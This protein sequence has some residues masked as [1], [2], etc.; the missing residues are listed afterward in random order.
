LDLD[1][2]TVR[3]LDDLCAQAE[4]FCGEE[5]IVFPGRVRHSRNPAVKS[6]ALVRNGLRDLLALMPGGW[7]AF[8]A[9]ER[10]YRS[11]ANNAVIGSAPRSRFVTRWL[12]RIP[13]LPP[14]VQR[15]YCGIGP[16]LVQ[17]LTPQ[18]SP[19]DLVV[20]PPPVFYPL[21][22]VVSRHWFYLRG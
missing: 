14:E 8:P 16:H 12:E 19:P 7:G 2:V 17:E 6:L 22:P 3:P 9:I 5:R 15:R 21:G 10:S 20:H 13:E 4:A 11:A 1:T 18:F